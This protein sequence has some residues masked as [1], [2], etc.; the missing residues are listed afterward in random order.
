MKK[1]YIL[2]NLGLLSLLAV[3]ACKTQE[4]SGLEA[5]SKT[6]FLTDEEKALVLEMKSYLETA[7]QKLE[8]MAIAEAIKQYV[9]VLGAGQR[10]DNSNP[11]ILKLINEA[12]SA[13]TK[14]ESGFLLKPAS[15]WLDENENQKTS[16][17][18]IQEGKGL[19]SPRLMIW[20]NAAG[21]YLALGGVPVVFE[22]VKGKGM[23]SGLATTNE[24]GE[25]FATLT[26]LENPHEESVIRASIVFNVKGYVYRFNQTY[27][28][29]VYLPPLKRAM[30]FVL[31]KAVNYQAD[32]PIIFNPI[33]NTLKRLDFDLIPYS[34][35]LLEAD[36]IR[37]FNGDTATIK[38]L[39]SEK[40]LPYLILVL[41]DCFR[42]GQITESAYVGEGRATLRI[43]RVAD[44]K[45]VFEALGTALKSDNTHGQGGSAEKVIRNVHTR[46]TLALGAALEKKW[47]EI[48]KALGIEH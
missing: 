14:L 29:F 38:R 42:I 4:S 19:L 16:S 26:K 23:V 5:Q 13:I 6:V 24:Y 47:S 40:N 25:A 45:L 15:E 17:S 27:V 3:F 46:T 36:F 39:A 34:G 37:A 21:S 8:E 20:Y 48:L 2:L 1:Q 9:A 32:D 12:A 30:L 22:F 44:G 31:E 41:N 10:Q 7:R 43:I 18:L 11:E 35:K 33:F 28:E